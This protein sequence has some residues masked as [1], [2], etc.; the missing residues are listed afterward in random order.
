M[1]DE[2]QYRN[3]RTWNKPIPSDK[4][5]ALKTFNVEPRMATHL[6]KLKY[7]VVPSLKGQKATWTQNRGC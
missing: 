5:P 7:S 3:L 6:D 2:L 4:P 1:T